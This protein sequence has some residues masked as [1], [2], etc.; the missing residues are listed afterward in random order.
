MVATSPQVY[1]L[2]KLDS[3]LTGDAAHK[4][5]RGATLVHLST[6]K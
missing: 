4:N 1:V 6:K 2:K 5:A 3:F